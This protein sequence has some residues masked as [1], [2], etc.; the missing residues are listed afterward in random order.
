MLKI[1]IRRK[2]QCGV[3]KSIPTDAENNDFGLQTDDQDDSD[4]A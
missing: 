3:A 1:R 2:G 4:V